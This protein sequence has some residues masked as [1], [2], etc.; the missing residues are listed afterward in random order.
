MSSFLDV[1]N[2]DEKIKNVIKDSIIDK[3]KKLESINKDIELLNKQESTQDYYVPLN[4]DPSLSIRYVGSSIISLAGDILDGFGKVAKQIKNDVDNTSKIQVG[5]S[6]SQESND[7]INKLKVESDNLNKAIEDAQNKIKELTTNM[8]TKSL[9]DGS[10]GSEYWKGVSK[11]KDMGVISAKTGIKWTEQFINKMI[12]LALDASGEKK[13]LNTPLSELSPELNKK[14]LLLA[15]VLKELSKNPA[16]KEAIKE[17]AEAI[18]VAII[19]IME[20]IK[21]ELDKV[22]DEAIELIDQVA[23]KSVRGATA[24]GLSVTQAFLAEIPYVGGVLDLLLAIG[25]GFNSFMEVFKTFSDKGGNYAVSSAKMVKNTES[26]VKKNIDRIQNAVDSAQETLK[27]ATNSDVKQ[28]PLKEDNISKAKREMETA[29]EDVNKKTELYN[30]MNT[31]NS[32]GNPDSQ[33]IGKFQ[34]AL[35]TQKSELEKSKKNAQEKTNYYES[36]LNS[37]NNVPIKQTAGGYK[38]Y[39][40][41][42]KTR[43]KIIKGGNRLRKSVKIFTNTL[44]KKKFTIKHFHKRNR[45]TNKRYNRK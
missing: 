16:T 27:E 9:G 5:G 38:E 17:I 20:E 35:N 28:E 10:V 26:T 40:P 32:S 42:N 36:L 14:L 33:D 21:P 18:G 41:N 44:G 22:T 19:E 34:A 37:N 11:V 6:G 24:T 3:Q 23:V 7:E 39:I 30:K 4:S 31:P 43:N 1:P 15:G 25:K 8:N 12:D 29:K 2:P 45:K 13:I